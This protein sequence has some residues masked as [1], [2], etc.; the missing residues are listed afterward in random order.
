VPAQLTGKHDTRPDVIA[1][2]ESTGN[3]Q[4]LVVVQQLRVFQKLK[5]MDPL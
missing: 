3:A 1:V 2:A 5:Q 4:N